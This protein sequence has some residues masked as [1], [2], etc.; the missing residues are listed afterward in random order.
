MAEV[1]GFNMVLARKLKAEGKTN[2]DA[3][4]RLMAHV[5]INKHGNRY[6]AKGEDAKTGDSMAIIMSADT[7]NDAIK[8]GHAKKGEGWD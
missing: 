2:E 4:G 8:T 6:V 3:K 7:A 5:L 1:R